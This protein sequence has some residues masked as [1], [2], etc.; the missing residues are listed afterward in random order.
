M[1]CLEAG[2]RHVRDESFFAS[3]KRKRKYESSGMVKKKKKQP[4]YVLIFRVFYELIIHELV[5][6]LSSNIYPFFQSPSPS[7]R[8]S[9]AVFPSSSPSSPS[10]SLSTVPP[11]TPPPTSSALPPPRPP[12]ATP[13]RHQ[14]PGIPP[15]LPAR[16]R[17]SMTNLHSTSSE[18]GIFRF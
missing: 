18:Q 14:T 3:H 11:G 4:E 6:L 13:E 12:P 8:P 16:N 15:P 2:E 10:P 1:L 5:I 9:S 7:T 17:T